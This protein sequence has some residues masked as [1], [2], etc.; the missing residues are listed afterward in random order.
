[1]KIGDMVVRSYAWH[2][3]VP[4][5]IVDEEIDVVTA[6]NE[7]YSYEQCEFVVQW[8]DGAQSKEL[9]EEL[10]YYEYVLKN[11]RLYNRDEEAALETSP[12]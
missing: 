1:M 8:S 11:E 6:N 4:G 9:F 3:L 10:D 12:K 5:I 7:E 2:S